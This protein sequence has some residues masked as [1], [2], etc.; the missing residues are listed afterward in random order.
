MKIL[1]SMIQFFL[2]FYKQEAKGRKQNAGMTY[3]ELVVV[4]SI[5]AIMSAIS[6]SNFKEF[7]NRI[8]LKNLATKIALKILEVQKNSVN[9]K[10]SPPAP[11]VQ[12]LPDWKPS[13]GVYFDLD[14]DQ[15]N[16][17]TDNQSF[18]I[19]AD[20]DQNGLFDKDFTCPNTGGECLEKI[21][22]NNSNYIYDVSD[23]TQQISLRNTPLILPE[24]HSN[25]TRP[26]F[27]PLFSTVV[28]GSHIEIVIAS[29]KIPVSPV[30]PDYPG[31]SII[32]IWTSG[33]IEIK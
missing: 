7:Q 30:P 13:Y 19:Y 9:G 20:L 27:K 6:F 18:F 23:N 21:T 33:R 14:L 3:I 25:F 29:S 15:N 16:V 26:S 8:E 32:K 2:K 24:L 4:M 10:L 1:T 31:A 11:W 22:L 17:Y 28:P 12:P 5:F